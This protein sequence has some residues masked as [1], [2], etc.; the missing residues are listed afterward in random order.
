MAEITTQVLASALVFVLALGVIVTSH[1]RAEYG[2]AAWLFVAGFVP[3]WVGPSLGVFVPAISVVTVLVYLGRRSR[4]RLRIKGAD[5]GVAVLGASVLLIAA[6][7][8]A[9]VSA[10]AVVIVQWLIAY[11]LGRHL[12]VLPHST[13]NRAFTL[14]GFALAALAVVEF[15]SDWHPA[16][17]LVLDNRPY[18]IWSPIQ[19]RGGVARSELAAGHSIALGVIIAM[20]IPFMIAS[21]L[22]RLRLG[23][24][25]IVAFMGVAV[26]FSRSAVVGAALSL[27]GSAVLLRRR[28]PASTVAVLG[29]GAVTAV[30]AFRI[31]GAVYEDA[32]S[33]LSSSLAIRFQML[34]LLRTLN[35]VGSAGNAVETVDGRI[36]FLGESGVYRTLD[37]AFLHLSLQFG[38]ILGAV[39]FGV[40][41]SFVA[42]LLTGRATP[43]AVAVAAQVPV[44]FTVAFITQYASLFWLIAGVAV[45]QASM[46]TR[47]EVALSLDQGRPAYAWTA[48]RRRLARVLT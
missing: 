1:T 44:L 42:L 47:P 25:L 34:E 23:L 19:Y 12:A 45:G 18:R 21:G 48:R 35:P 10:A 39:L 33:E 27:A 15:V 8:G 11:F 13:L 3:Y 14:F 9:E 16:A 26:T 29:A 36:G 24:V 7:G 20:T 41:A 38:W 46:R 30:A 28:R 5:W 37:N 4:G 40:C 43:A 6:L 31:F 17:A 22:R 32:A 2:L